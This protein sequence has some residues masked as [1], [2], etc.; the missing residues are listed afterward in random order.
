MLHDDGSGFWPHAGRDVVEVPVRHDVQ[1]DHHARLVEA[2]PHRVEVRVGGA[3][4]VGRAGGQQHHLGAPVEDHV[5]ELHRLVEVAQAEQRGGVEPVLVVEAPRLVEPAVVGVQV[6]VERLGVVDVTL[7]RE[8]DGRREEH[9]APDALLVEHLQARLAFE[10]LGAHGLP[11]VLGV[12]VARRHLLEQL[13]ERP[14]D[15]RVVE[16]DALLAVEVA[17]RCPASTTSS[18]LPLCTTRSD[19]SRYFSGR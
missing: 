8:R 17:M 13:L 5:G 18:P 11:H 6:G 12:R 14:G 19:A 4:A 1:R 16:P 3:A 9:A 7:G 15:V 10:V 2:R